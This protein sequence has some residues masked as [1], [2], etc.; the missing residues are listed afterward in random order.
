[1]T[2]SVRRLA[3]TRSELTLVDK[4]LRFLA[5]LPQRPGEEWLTDAER[6][7]VPSILQK[8]EA[9]QQQ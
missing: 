7:R 5:G 3:L 4:A 9:K 8:I 1:M 2:D 6:D